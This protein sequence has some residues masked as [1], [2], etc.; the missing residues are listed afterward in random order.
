[1][2]T[3]S[4]IELLTLIKNE[5]KAFRVLYDRYWSRLYFYALNV[6]NDPKIC[7][8]IVQDV[9]TDLWQNAHQKDVQNVA[10]YLH[11]ATKYKIFNTLRNGKTRQSHLE[12]ISQLQSQ[13]QLSDPL[14]ATELESMIKQLISELPKRCQQIFLLSRF[15]YL[16]NQE[17][18]DKL[19]ISLQTVKNQISK[20]LAYLREHLEVKMTSLLLFLLLV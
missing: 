15:E 6:L 7:E 18:A 9:F 4:D 8:D 19:G 1:M 2:E 13:P 12:R 20:A 14:E 5:E 11:Q 10:A 3:W 16:S 17:I